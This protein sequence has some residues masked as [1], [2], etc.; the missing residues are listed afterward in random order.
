MIIRIV[1]PDGGKDEFELFDDII[2]IG[3][4]K[5]C[6]IV[7]ADDHISRKHLEIKNIGGLVYIKDLTLSNWVSYNDEKLPKELDVQYYDFAPLLLPGNY[8]VE[9]DADSGNLDMSS[10]GH[11]M[12]IMQ[13]D[14]KPVSMAVNT[15]SAKLKEF[16]DLEKEKIA[17]EKNKKQ[18]RSL[19]EKKKK[20]NKNELMVF[21]LITL[22]AIGYVVYESVINVHNPAPPKLKKI[23]KVIPSERLKPITPPKVEESEP[24]TTSEVNQKTPPSLLLGK[25]CQ[26][27]IEKALCQV[28]FKNL[29]EFEGVKES[30]YVLHVYKNLLNTAVELFGD[31]KTVS[32]LA[33]K[34]KN[35]TKAIAGQYI[36]LPSFLEAAEK[37][38]KSFIEIH[39]FNKTAEGPEVVHTFE[40]DVTDYRKF[41]AEDYPKA[42][43]LIKNKDFSYF[44]KE[45]SEHI[46]VKKK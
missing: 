32:E 45:L 7:L 33:V 31:I 28:I 46:K 30:D 34:N 9:I 2:T 27:P 5:N 26:S 17:K 20:K 36:I 19:K 29:S 6:D 12:D 42:Y 1:S 43:E 41:D 24:E 4:G 25:K 44:D 23:K 37:N 14:L 40:V 35:M 22:G 39:L 15:H 11:K 21:I 13:D 8:Q 3:R 18:A 16:A 38:N 10:S